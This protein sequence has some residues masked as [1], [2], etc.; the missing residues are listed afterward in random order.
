MQILFT[1]FSNST[2]GFYIP[3]YRSYFLLSVI[4][5]QD[6]TFLHTDPMKL[7][8]YWIA[9]EDADTENGCLY[10]YPG[11]HKSKN[12]KSLRKLK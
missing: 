9:L 12:R 5:H 4:P 11:S 1:T 2:P 3:L 10:F 7:F 6:A 8:G